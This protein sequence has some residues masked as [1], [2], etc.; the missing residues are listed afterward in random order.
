MGCPC[1]PGLIAV[2]LRRGDY[3]Q[4]Y[5]HLTSELAE[6]RFWST[7]G[8]YSVSKPTFP[9][10]GIERVQAKPGHSRVS[11]PVRTSKGDGGSGGNQDWRHRPQTIAVIYTY[12]STNETQNTSSINA[13]CIPITGIRQ[14]SHPERVVHH[15][16]LPDHCDTSFP[17]LN[18]TLYDPPYV[19]ASPYT[20][21]ED[22]T[23]DPTTLTL[24]ELIVYHCWQDIHLIRDRLHVVREWQR[25]KK[26]RKLK[27][28]YILT[29]EKD[30]FRSNS[31]A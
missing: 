31:S 2:H 12:Y 10:S 4:H 27:D 26:E 29:N 25:A 13:Q 14:S 22:V 24:E 9:V 21:N 8:S 19:T 16:I 6:Y 15:D 23:I 28:V 18:D 17:K 1:P 11:R 5:R 7:L 3:E 20:K 30:N